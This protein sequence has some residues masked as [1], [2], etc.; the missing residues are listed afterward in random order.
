METFIA[1]FDETGDDGRTTASSDVFVLSSVYMKTDDW[2][3]NYDQF[4]EFRK[5]IKKTYGMHVTQEMHTMQFVRDK[6]LYR[7]YGWTI[8]DRKSILEAFAKAISGLAIQVI[9]VVID[10]NNITTQDYSVLETA[11][12]YNIQ[13][14]ENDSNGKW[15]YLI[16]SD[17]GRI[18]PMRKIARKIRSVNFVQSHFGGFV[19]RPIGSLVEDI[20]EKDSKES[21]FIQI[22][23]FVS[24]FVGLYYKYV[25]KG[26]T[27]PKR[28]A[29]I[30]GKEE[31]ASIM[32]IFKE[33]G[34][35]NEKAGPYEYGLVVY[36]RA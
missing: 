31:I 17:K 29:Q 3:N 26:E 19:N 24:C 23:D 12:T 15:K 36:P 33:G 8:E 5:S 7:A 6:G 14:I 9:N 13:R 34:I 32:E 27:L 30:M 2:Q 4:K 28:I 22:S 16:I 10:K 35:L 25:K 20:M 21:Y 1:Y 18:V 11:L